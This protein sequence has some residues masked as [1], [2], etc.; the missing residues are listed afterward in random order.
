MLLLS[1]IDFLQQ[2]CY[3]SVNDDFNT[4][5]KSLISFLTTHTIMSY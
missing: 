5:I 4:Q 3:L 2:N 1:F